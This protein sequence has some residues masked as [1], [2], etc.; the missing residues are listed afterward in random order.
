M[1]HCHQP[2]SS[3]A[4]AAILPETARLERVVL[5][6]LAQYPAGLTVDET[7][8]VAEYPRYSLQP[9]FTALKDRRVIRDTGV[10][11]PNVS[12]RNAIV[13]RVCHLDR[14]EGQA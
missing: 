7:C 9:R 11:R 5:N 14:Q 3:A 10:R 8:A 4:Y 12:G 13:W 1:T 2:T 6:V